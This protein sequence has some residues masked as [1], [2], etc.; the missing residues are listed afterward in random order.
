MTTC[1]CFLCGSRA[2]PRPPHARLSAFR[3]RS[4]EI[5]DY[6][7]NSRIEGSGLHAD[8][9]KLMMK[10]EYTSAEGC[11]KAMNNIFSQPEEI[12]KEFGK[13]VKF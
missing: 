9:A 11:V 5:I 3:F 13:Y 7:L 1:S 10:V 2:G 6:E 12:V 8:A 4:E